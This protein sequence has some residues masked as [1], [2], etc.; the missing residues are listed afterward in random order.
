MLRS[1]LAILLLLAAQTGLAQGI[2]VDAARSRVIILVEKSGL[3]SAFAHNHRIEAP[4]KTG[5]LD[6]EKRSVELAFNARDMKVMDE[7]GSDSDHAEIDR[8]M[9]GEKVLDAARFPE[10]GFK[11][12]RV[13][14][15]RDSY[16]VHGELTLHGVS[17][18]LDMAVSFAN[19]RYTGSVKLKQSDFGITPVKVAGGTVKVKDEIEVRIEIV[20]VPAAKN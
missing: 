11:S 17:R 13:A 6:G 7:E 20:A 16:L 19:N 3:F 8:T 5:R 15:N 14:R 10:I 9:K 1:A 4:V 12:T 18:E 2:E